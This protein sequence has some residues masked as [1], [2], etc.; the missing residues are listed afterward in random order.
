MR[1]PP[2]F[3]HKLDGIPL[4]RTST[5]RRQLLEHASLLHVGIGHHHYIIPV[6]ESSTKRV[7]RLSPADAQEVV[8]VVAIDLSRLL[9][10]A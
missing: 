5:R 6:I 9:P 10:R 8:V 1:Q 2:Q 4:P 3:F 7:H